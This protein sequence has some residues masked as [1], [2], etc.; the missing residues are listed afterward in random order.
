MTG[1]SFTTWNKAS[2]EVSP[3]LPPSPERLGERAFISRRCLSLYQ[4][5]DVISRS[6]GKTSLG[7]NTDKGLV[8]FLQKYIQ[9]DRESTYV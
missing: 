5:R 9:R 4:Q 6:L 2:T 3:L 7:H 8:Q 1:G